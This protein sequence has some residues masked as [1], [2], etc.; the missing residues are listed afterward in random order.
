MDWISTAT[1][2]VCVLLPRFVAGVCNLLASYLDNLGQHI[3]PLDREL[4]IRYIEFGN[5]P[6]RAQNGGHMREA[7]ISDVVPAQF[8]SL[9]DV[10]GY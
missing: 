8:Q 5:V 1:A 9:E 2:M 6:M 3:R 10:V 4:I 7:L